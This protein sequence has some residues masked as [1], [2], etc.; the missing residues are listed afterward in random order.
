[1]NE[2]M[3]HSFVLLSESVFL[4]QIGWINDLMAAS[5]IVFFWISSY[6]TTF[7]KRLFYMN[8]CSMIVILMY[9]ICYPQIFSR[10]LMG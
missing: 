6:F 5:E 10:G 1:M 8:V 4:E 2:T 3:T 7:K 9:Y